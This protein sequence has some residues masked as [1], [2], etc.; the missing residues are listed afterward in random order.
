MDMDALLGEVDFEQ[1]RY[2]LTQSTQ[3]D[4]KTIMGN[5]RNMQ[6]KDLN[7]FNI[8]MRGSIMLRSR[9]PSQVTLESFEL[10]Q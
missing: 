8:D 10:L 1:N 4:S 9:R 3:D 6:L 5:S 7:D 2:S